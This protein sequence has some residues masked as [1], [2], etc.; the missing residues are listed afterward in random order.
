MKKYRIRHALEQ[1]FVSSP[2]LP[3]S[4]LPRRGKSPFRRQF[5][6]L[7]RFPSGAIVRAMI[8][9]QQMH[10]L[11]VMGCLFLVYLSWGSSFISNKFALES[12][13]AFI[14]CGFRM[15]LAGL[16]LYALTWIRGERNVPTP[17]DLFRSVI[18]AFFMVFIASGFLAK[19]Q[20]SVSSGTAAMILGAIPIWMVLGGWLFCGDPKPTKLQFAGLVCGFSGLVLLSFHQGISGD[21]SLFGIFLVLLAALGWVAGSFYSKMRGGQT[22]LSVMRTSALLMALG[23]MQSLAWAFVSGESQDFS[24]SDV[25]GVSWAAML[26]LII[27]GGIIAYTCYFWLLMHTRTVVAISY[28]YVN[29]VI[30]VFLG[31]WLAGEHVDPTIILACFLTVASVFFVV[32]RHKD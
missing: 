5:L 7:N 20:E 30:G 8:T 1:G 6:L 11:Q 24:F 22:K 26:Y 25:S 32:S 3:D 29:P 15:G 18:L 27:S 2:D 14:M 31:W 10:R 4:G 12:F 21:D 16:L 19:G 28:E 17:S 23:G 13:P 9:Q